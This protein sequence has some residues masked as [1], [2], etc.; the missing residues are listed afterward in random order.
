MPVATSIA[1]SAAGAVAGVH[2]LRAPRPAARRPARRRSGTGACSES[3]TSANCSAR[4]GRR[5]SSPP[6]TADQASF[7]PATRLRACATSAG[8][9][10]PSSAV[11]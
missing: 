9:K 1:S 8:S 6:A 11:S 7:A 3:P 10:R 2:G 5:C 4:P